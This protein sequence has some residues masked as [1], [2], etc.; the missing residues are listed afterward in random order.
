MRRK[1]RSENEYKKR[2]DHVLDYIQEHLFEPINLEK[3]ATE[4]YFS[5]FHFHRIFTSIT[6]ET[7]N[8]YVVR[9]RLEKAANM[10]FVRRNTTI[11]DIAYTCGFSS[12]AVFSRSFKKHFGIS[13]SSFA[14]RHIGDYHALNRPQNK[15]VSVKKEFDLSQIKIKKLP[16]FNF[17]Y[18]RCNNGYGKGNLKAWEKIIKFALYND[19][20]TPDTKYVGIPFDNPGITPENKCRYYACL[21]VPDDYIYEGN[22]FSTLKINEGKYAVYHFIGKE[23]DMSAAYSNIYGK[24]LPES[25]FIHHK[26]YI[27]ELYPWEQGIQSDIDN[28]E[29]D[30][31]LPVKPL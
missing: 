30:I 16:A 18:T 5:P 9:L 31:A 3:I 8:D 21:T 24:W 12:P 17:I 23:E 14:A 11:T 29:Y 7:P 26:G 27:L 28:F 1:S 13:A 15:E 4:A 2:I 20:I 19:L 22:E 6:G 25:G 10:L